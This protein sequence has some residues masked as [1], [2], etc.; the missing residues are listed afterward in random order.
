MLKEEFRS[1]ATYSGKERFLTFPFFVFAISV[2][3]GLSIERISETVSLAELATVSHLS[4]FIYGLSVGAFGLMGRQY[5]ERRYG[6]SNY[7]VAMPFLLPFTFRTA[8]LAIFLRD[9]IF[10]I[11]LLLVPA[12]LG[13]VAVSAVM[14]FSLASIALFFLAILASFMMGLSLSFLASVLYIRNIAA[15]LVM[16]AF[17]AVLFVMHLAIGTPP[18]NALLPPLEFQMN[19]SPLG[20]DDTAAIVSMAW[21]SAL[22]SAMTLAAF[23]LVAI[24]MESS[25]QTHPIVLPSY[26]ARI[27]LVKGLNRTLIAKEFVD[28]RRSGTVAKM[29]FSLV[30]PLLFLSFTAWFVNHGLAIPVGF[31]TVFYAAMVGFIGILMYNW[32]N[33]IDL[34]EYYS[35][36]PV[37]VPQLIRVRIVVFLVLTLGIS[38][39]FVVGISVINGD[40]QLLW[41]A[42][43]VMF[44][45]SLYMAALTAYLTGL[46]TNTFLFDTSVLA[47]FSVM[48]F[49]P[50][51]CLTILSFSLLSNWAAASAGILIVLFSM[52]FTTWIL[53]R[54]IQTKWE[55][56][57]F[58]EGS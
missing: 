45:T 19:V 28:L 41:L 46:K 49:L 35:L 16:T 43:V 27:P 57:G 31:N 30:L 1:H 53:Y 2:V 58:A 32:L 36:I 51:V 15:F 11:V 34:S 42:L 24:R 56:F 55:H 37:T 21:S 47:K 6:R 9:A 7:L 17:V 26:H 4:A 18:L 48:S 22:I 50:D 39:S 44:V 20:G 12:T 40:T 5:L 33:N 8:F 3:V 25:S 38:A 13:L 10:Y 29:F 54:G 23:A 14:A 52:L